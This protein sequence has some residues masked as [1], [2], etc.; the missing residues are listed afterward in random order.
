MKIYKA[1]EGKTKKCMSDLMTK[2]GDYRTFMHKGVA[3][4]NRLLSTGAVLHSFYL[5]PP[6]TYTPIPKKTYQSWLNPNQTDPIYAIKD[7]PFGFKKEQSAAQAINRCL[8]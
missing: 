8:N 5:P 4:V 7:V 1:C 6:Y 2:M 3:K